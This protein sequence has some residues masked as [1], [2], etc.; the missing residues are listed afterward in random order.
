M[1]I[2]HSVWTKPMVGNRWNLGNV[3]KSNIWLFSLS[4][5]YAKRLGLEIVLH[6]DTQ[7]KDIFNFL[8]YDK[9]FLTLDKINHIHERFWAA[10]KI[11]A[12]EAEPLG[13]VHIDGDVFLKKSNVVKMLRE[14]GYDLFVQ[15]IE[16]DESQSCLGS[17]YAENLDF[18]RRGL[19]NN[20]PV[21]LNYNMEAALNCGLVAFHNAELKKKYIEG[22]KKMLETCS[23]SQSFVKR[24]IADPNICPDLIMEQWF[25]FSVA[26][27]YGAKIKTIIPNWGFNT[28]YLNDI[29]FTHLIGKKKY[30][31]IPEVKKWLNIISPVIYGNAENQIKKLNL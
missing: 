19:G 24:L 9:V 15:M 10:G 26:S 23:S 13:S 4:V 22:Y 17:C 5:A 7:G 18:V 11:F 30:G 16:G 25:L 2:A 21:E 20:K 27:F 1:R 3:L 6:T 8:P 29:G 14:K 31:V 28:D 12:Q